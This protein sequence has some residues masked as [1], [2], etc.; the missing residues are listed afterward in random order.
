[1]RGIAVPD[2]TQPDTFVC[3]FIPMEVQA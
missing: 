2:T 1:M 3:H